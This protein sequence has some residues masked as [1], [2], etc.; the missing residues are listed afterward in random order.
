MSAAVSGVVLATR[1]GKWSVVAITREDASSSG[2][3][4]RRNAMDGWMS[5]EANEGEIRDYHS[6]EY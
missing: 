2:V 3:C 1:R 5:T 4:D 6:G